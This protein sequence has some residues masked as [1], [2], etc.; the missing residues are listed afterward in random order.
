MNQHK[1]YMIQLDTLRAISIILVLIQHFS[2]KKSFFGSEGVFPVG[3]IGVDI[4]FVL[5]GF[6]ITRSLIREKDE[7]ITLAKKAFRFT[8]KRAIRLFPVYYLVLFIGLAF[9]FYNIRE[10]WPWMFGYASNFLA[11]KEG[12]PTWGY[13]QFWSLAVEE[14]FYLFWP[15]FIWFFPIRTL[16]GAFLAFISSGIIIRGIMFY[17]DAPPIAIR[18]STFALLDLFGMGAILAYYHHYKLAEAKRNLFKNLAWVGLAG[19]IAVVGCRIAKVPM[20]SSPGVA[21][22]FFSFFGSL[23]YVHLVNMTAIGLNWGKGF[24]ENPF[25]IHV[26][27]VSYGIYVYHNFVLLLLPAALA[28][29]GLSMTNIFILDFIILSAVTLLISTLS[30]H[31][32]EKQVLKLKDRL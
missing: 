18:F 29:I 7:D 17:M 12:H 15:W 4:F 11:A 14:Q 32:Y 21:L 3:F 5:S 1:G 9:N 24:W 22:M 8:A 19:M 27:K 13:T 16:K 30:W 6:L 10:F 26:G 31:A 25:L 20:L 28:A 2:P 23:V